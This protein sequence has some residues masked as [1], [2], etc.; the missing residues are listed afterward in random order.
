MVRVELAALVHGIGR[1]K[2]RVAACARYGNIPASLRHLA[3][4]PGAPILLRVHQLEAAVRQ[5]FIRSEGAAI[6]IDKS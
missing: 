6:R 5:Y 1:N 3:G 2:C 4:P